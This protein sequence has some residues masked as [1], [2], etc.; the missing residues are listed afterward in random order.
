MAAQRARPASKRVSMNAQA[1]AVSPSASRGSGDSSGP[2]KLILA[3]LRGHLLHESGQQVAK[4]DSD[5]PHEM[6]QK[7]W[8]TEGAPWRAVGRGNGKF[9]WARFL[10]AG[11]ANS[12]LTAPADWVKAK[13]SW[14]FLRH[15]WH[16]RRCQHH[17]T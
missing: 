4:R 2:V 10:T 9:V 16:L 14:R 15:V 3:N 6:L 8:F 7:N 12:Q 5:I 17:T 13:S 11:A 1:V